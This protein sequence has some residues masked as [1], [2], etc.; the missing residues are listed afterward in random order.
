L[1]AA[2]DRLRDAVNPAF[3]QT[4]GRFLTD[5]RAARDDYIDI[6]VDR[7]PMPLALFSLSQ[8]ESLHATNGR[9]NTSVARNTLSIQATTFHR[10]NLSI[11]IGNYCKQLKKQLLIRLA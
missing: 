10:T 2:L 6:I 5:P 4:A 1:R 7:A 11:S 8:I 9:C 3:E